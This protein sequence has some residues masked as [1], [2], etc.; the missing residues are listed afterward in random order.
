MLGSNL[1]PS[2]HRAHS[3]LRSE[4]NQIETL[5]IRPESGSP[6][7]RMLEQTRQRSREPPDQNDR[8]ERQLQARL[9]SGD[10]LERELQQHQHNDQHRQRAGHRPGQVQQDRQVLVRAEQPER[11]G[12]AVLLAVELV[13]TSRRDGNASRRSMRQVLGRNRRLRLHRPQQPSTKQ[14]GLEQQERILN[15]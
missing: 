9:V 2:V 4:A 13:R 14:L 1:L 11:G 3:L 6:L 10:S 15:R 8:P 7:G 12:V 5:R